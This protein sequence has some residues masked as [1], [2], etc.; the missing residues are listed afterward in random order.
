MFPTSSRLLRN[1]IASN[2]W[3]VFVNPDSTTTSASSFHF[4]AIALFAFS[5]QRCCKNRFSHSHAPC[6][7]YFFVLR[8]QRGASIFSFCNTSQ[9]ILRFS[10]LPAG[11]PRPTQGRRCGSSGM[12]TC[13]A[14]PLATA[15]CEEKRVVHDYMG[16]AGGR[17]SRRELVPLWGG[18]LRSVAKAGILLSSI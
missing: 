14:A 10:M 2:V 7:A 5:L 11:A 18:E 17:A 12:H 1:I 3:C 4:D 16:R 15:Q 13:C 8:M 6:R 9:L